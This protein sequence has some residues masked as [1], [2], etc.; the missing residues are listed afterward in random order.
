MLYTK[1]SLV[2]EIYPVLKKRS[3]ITVVISEQRKHVFHMHIVYTIVYT[4]VFSSLFTEVVVLRIFKW[5]N[6]VFSYQSE[7]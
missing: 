6:T 4:S 7:I 3:D 1:F 5:V 2:T